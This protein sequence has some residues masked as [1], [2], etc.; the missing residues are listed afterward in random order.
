MDHANY[1]PSSAILH[2]FPDHAELDLD[3]IL[4]G[5]AVFLVNEN[6]NENYNKLKNKQTRLCSESAN[7]RQGV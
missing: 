5:S 7:L 4:G 3:A 6:E 2:G 1:R